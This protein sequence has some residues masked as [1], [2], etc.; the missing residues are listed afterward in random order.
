MTAGDDLPREAVRR[1]AQTG[2]A[3]GRGARYDRSVVLAPGTL[4]TP[5]V[6]LLEP[7]GEGGMGTVWVAEH[8]ALDARVAVKFILPERR[9]ERE[10]L[11]GR[12]RQE[13]SVAARLTSP[14]VVRIFDYGV[15]DEQTPFMVMEL[16][17]G[18]PLSQRLHDGGKLP[19]RAAG[20]VVGQ[21]A[22][23]LGEAH[24]LGVVHRDIKPSNL[25]LVDSGDG[26]LALDDDLFVKVLDFGVA[27]RLDADDAST[28]LTASGAMVGTPL[29]MSPEQIDDSRAIDQRVDLWALAVV[30]YEC[31]TGVLPFRGRTLARLMAAIGSGAFEPPSRLVPS[32]PAA[33]DAWF[34]RAFHVLIDERFGSAREMAAELARA[35][36]S[37]SRDGVLAEIVSGDWPSGDDAPTAT[38]SDTADATVAAP[39]RPLTPRAGV[40]D[41]RAGLAASDSH[42]AF[43][44]RD[45]ESSD[46]PGSGS[47]D[48]ADETGPGERKSATLP[49]TAAPVSGAPRRGRRWLVGGALAVSAAL[50]IPMLARMAGDPPSRADGTTAPSAAASPTGLSSPPTALRPLAVAPVPFSSSASSAA[51]AAVSESSDSPLGA[52]SSATDKPAASSVHASQPPPVV[53]PTT[54]PART[55]S[56]TPSPSTAPSTTAAS[57]S[58]KPAQGKPDYCHGDTA[59][60]VDEHGFFVPRPECL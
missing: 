15:L 60:R 55:T 24:R 1:P 21:V 37:K 47:D 38:R 29:Y 33:L 6:R 35:L 53:A 13:A 3:R 46:A 2:D 11:V 5:Q 39:M 28:G 48:G 49:G 19:V 54:A 23:V 42:D 56:V 22:K 4:V 17:R 52:A 41:A 25:F 30:A 50:A 9:K 18:V 31:V 58:A 14:H 26:E 20:R 44:A 16:L 57:P 8:L 32:L 12:F 36:A 10:S 45:A 51:G 40:E 27:K 59:F 43:A 7:L 34:S